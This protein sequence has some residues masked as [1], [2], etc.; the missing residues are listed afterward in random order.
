MIR[1][2]RILRPLPAVALLWLAAGGSNDPADSQP[3]IAAAPVTLPLQRGFY[4]ASDTACGAASNATL[5]LFRGDGFSGSHDSCDFKTI[6]R[7]GPQT[8][9]VTEHCDDF[10]AG[11]DSATTQLVDYR[12]PDDTRFISKSND[13]WERD[14]RYC[15]QSSLPQD[16]RDADISELT[17]TGAP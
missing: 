17:G 1:S 7:T 5:L 3:S 6:E 11:P 9:R 12:L 16:W 13:G 15:Q 4:V 8:Y 2:T 14:F 10:Q